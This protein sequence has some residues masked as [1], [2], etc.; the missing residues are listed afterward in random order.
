LLLQRRFIMSKFSLPDYSSKQKILYVD[1]TNPDVLKNYGDMLL[2]EGMLSDAL[3]FYQKANNSDGL[4][5]IKDGALDRGDVMLF[6]Q[7]AKA[8]NIE[9]TPADWE[10]I[11]QKAIELK[12]YSFAQ[13]ALK[14][15]NND[16]MLNSLKKIMQNEVDVKSA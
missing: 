12:K 13:Q 10:G 4:Q 3:E 2:E 7:S 16:G 15:A 1:K 6:L 11:A 14:K 5:K 8:L 9:L